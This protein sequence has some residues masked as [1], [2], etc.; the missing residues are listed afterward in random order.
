MKNIFN[1]RLIFILVVAICGSSMEAKPLYNVSRLIDRGNGD[2]R[3]CD[4]HRGVSPQMKSARPG[5]N[6][7]LQQIKEISLLLAKEFP[8]TGPGAVAL[9]ARE[10]RIL[11]QQAFGKADLE[12]NTPMQ[13]AHIFRIAS[14]TKQFTACAILRLAEQGRLS[15]HD[16]IRKFIT[17][18][19]T[20]GKPITIEHLLTHTSGINSSA[21]QWTPQMRRMD[22][23]P[24]QLVDSFKNRQAEFLPGTD[25]R[26][27]NN[28]YVLLGYIIEIITGNSYEDDITRQFFQPLGMKHSSF[29]TNNEIIVNRA[30]GYEKEDDK[31]KNAT[32]LSMSQPYAAGGILSTVEDMY[33]WNESLMSCKV[34]SK[35]SL[36]K[37]LT[38]G[39]LS[40]GKSTGYGYGWWRGRI[41]GSPDVHHD[42]LI[43][44]FS[45][46]AVYLPNEKIF[47]TLFTNC[48]NNNPELTASKIAA[49]VIGKP[50]P[51]QEITMPAE[52]LA[53]M[54]GVYE[55]S[56][57]EERVV[58]FENDRL[59]FFP[60]G[61]GKTGLFPFKKDQC[62]MDKSMNTVLFT[63]DSSQRINALVFNEPG[64]STTWQRTQKKVVKMKGVPVDTAVLEKYVGEYR[65]DNNFILIISREGQRMFGKGA[66]PRQVKQEIVPY[67]PLQFYAKN[68]DATL[69][70]KQD[71]QGR[72]SGLVKMQNGKQEAQKIDQ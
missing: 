55:S 9:V 68:L 40:S 31:Y 49:I 64:G 21:G 19:P 42:G 59:L 5:N 20:S 23:T 66:G 62:W 44:G 60:R 41:Q 33:K 35:T 30:R 10:D 15:L 50:F 67:A 34:I 32:F 71:Q 11:Y 17:D 1:S 6:L 7:T 65:F 24:R 28:G 58:S 8:A 69:I 4:Q 39:K 2:R 22:F 45:S 61:G 18:Y 48:E 12:M 25:F 51:Q 27:N 37:A 13:T 16:D 56:K 72:V 52:Q 38:P 26:Y 36:E 47:V 14:I 3:C 43:N 70:F 54:E 46:F 63:R 57:G 53:A 29:D